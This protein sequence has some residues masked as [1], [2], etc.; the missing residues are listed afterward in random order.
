MPRQSEPYNN[1]GNV[2]SRRGEHEAALEMYGRAIGLGPERGVGDLYANLA[3]TYMDLERPAEART[4]LQLALEEDPENPRLHLS[5]GRA[6]RMLGD[7]AAAEDSFERAIALAPGI[8]TNHAELADLFRASH[9]HSRA[10]SSY[11]RALAIDSTYARAW[12]GYA[13]SL[14]AMGQTSAAMTAYGRFL[15]VWP[16]RD[17]NHLHARARL[18]ELAR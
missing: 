6:A 14:D 10:I 3:G 7:G 1:L 8:K 4:A 17:A 15:K 16:R 12:S 9:H 5:S 2:L 18:R 11:E 13:R